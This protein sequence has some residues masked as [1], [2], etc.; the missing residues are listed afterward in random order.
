MEDTATLSIVF[1][2]VIIRSLSAVKKQI[3]F[4]L[5][6]MNADTTRIKPDLRQSG[7]FLTGDAIDRHPLSIL[8][9]FRAKPAVIIYYSFYLYLWCSKVNEQTYRQPGGFKIID[10]LCFMN[11]FNI[12]YSFQFNKNV[13]FYQQIRKIFSDQCFFIIYRYCPLLLDLKTFLSQFV[14]KCVLIDFFKKS[15]TKG[16]GYGVSTANDLFSQL[17]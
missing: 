8:S 13:S 6:Q 7:Y 3:L 4:I 2:Q 15:A 17:F 11:V 12:F 10:T 9:T 14:S 5:P 16:I 1:H